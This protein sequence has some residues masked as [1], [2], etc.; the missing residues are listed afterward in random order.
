MKPPSSRIAYVHLVTFSM[1]KVKQSHG[2]AY[3]TKTAFLCFPKSLLT[4]HSQGFLP[5]KVMR[6][7]WL[8]KFIYTSVSSED[9]QILEFPATG[10]LGSSLSPQGLYLCVGI[11]YGGSWCLH[12]YFHLSPQERCHKRG[13]KRWR[14]HGFVLGGYTG[15]ALHKQVTITVGKKHWKRA[16][17]EPYL[18]ILPACT[19]TQITMPHSD[20]CTTLCLPIT[21]LQHS[22]SLA[23]PRGCLCVAGEW[24]LLALHTSHQPP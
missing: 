1:P 9:F 7:Q 3:T 22:W 10:S 5:T 18:L 24:A 23:L 16:V 14:G 17:R 15:W 4:S 20:C 8:S 13:N 21:P 11:Y 2:S 19:T 12:P 6:L